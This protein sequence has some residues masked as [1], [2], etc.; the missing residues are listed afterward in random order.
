M[1]DSS[2]YHWIIVTLLATGNLIT[3]MQRVN[4]NFAM[5]YMV[6]NT[7]HSNTSSLLSTSNQGEFNWSPFDQ[8]LLLSGFYIGYL[9]TQILGG[10]LSD[11]FGGKHVVSVSLLVSS[12]FTA[13]IPSMAR[14]N[15]YA[16]LVVR[17]IIGCTHGPFYPC[18]L[19]LIRCS[20]KIIIM[21]AKNL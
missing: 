19:S 20:T 8:G 16:L 11:R 17:I 9:L 7:L 15:K 12:I 21:F 1:M 5:V 6:N 10:Y 14:W 18:W 3:F 2:N 13:F 4:M